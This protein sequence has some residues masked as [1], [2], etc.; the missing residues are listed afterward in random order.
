[1]KTVLKNLP[2]VPVRSRIT[3]RGRREG[4]GV[5]GMMGSKGKE[6]RKGRRERRGRRKG[7]EEKE[8]EEEKEMKRNWRIHLLVGVNKTKF[9]QAYHSEIEAN[10]SKT[11]LK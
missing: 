9:Q 4:S 8:R 6:W 5:R 10:G 2:M 7:G 1:M 11:C 3:Q